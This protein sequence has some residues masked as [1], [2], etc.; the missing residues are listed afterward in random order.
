MSCPQHA[1]SLGALD[2]SQ[3]AT[4]VAAW[5]ERMRAHSEDSAYVHLIVNEGPEA[6]ASLEW[7]QAP[8]VDSTSG[9]TLGGQTFGSQTTTGAFPGPETTTP[10]YPSLGSYSIDLPPASAAMLTR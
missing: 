4:A 2:D 6:G 5:R 8:S 9:V 3:F 10:V 7:L 1:T